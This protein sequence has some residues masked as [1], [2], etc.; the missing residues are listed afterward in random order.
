MLADCSFRVL[1]NLWL[2]AAEDETLEGVLPSFDDIAFRLRMD[3]SKLRK[4]LQDLDSFLLADCKQVATKNAPETETETETE[5]EADGDFGEFWIAYPKKKGKGAA[6]KAW[7]KLKP[8]LAA[9]LKAIR[10]EMRTDQWMREGGRFIPYPSK[11][12][13]EA[14][15]EDEIAAGAT[16]DPIHDRSGVPTEAE[17]ENILNDGV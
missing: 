3:K 4:A 13:N 7:A 1:I 14:R 10:A 17:L 2:L 5:T 6:Q 11:W 8:P 9:A 15:W 16:T 12:L